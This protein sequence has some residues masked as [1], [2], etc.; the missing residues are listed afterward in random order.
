M[1]ITK[2]IFKDNLIKH[3][4]VIVGILILG[5]IIYANPSCLAYF[6]NNRNNTKNII[7]SSQEAVDK[8]ISFINKN[9]LSDGMTAS[10]ID[11]VEENGL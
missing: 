10:L 6:T 7:L 5:A 2:Y 4:I 3:W 9:M 1:E 11:I 8:I